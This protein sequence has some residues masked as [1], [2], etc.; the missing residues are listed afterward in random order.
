MAL[1]TLRLDDGIASKGKRPLHMEG[2]AVRARNCLHFPDSRLA[3]IRVSGQSRRG[4]VRRHQQW[5]KN[6][7]IFHRHHGALRLKRQHGMCHQNDPDHG[8]EGWSRGTVHS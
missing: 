5:R 6:G 8:P 7:G 3:N 1:W 4:I 2:R